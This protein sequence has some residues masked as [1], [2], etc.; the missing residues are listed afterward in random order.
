MADNTTQSLVLK[1][2]GW[3]YEAGLTGLPRLKLAS[4]KELADEYTK[5]SGT[6]QTIQERA[7]AL[8][9]A[10]ITWAAAAGVLTGFGGLATLPVGVAS[11]LASTYFVQLRMIEAIAIMGKYDVQSPQVRMLS[12][13][14]MC[15]SSAAEIATE[16]GV[17]LGE[18][19]TQKALANIS[20]RVAVDVEEKVASR[21]VVRVGEDGLLHAGR[22]IP[23]LGGLILGGL[24]AYMTNEIGDVARDLFLPP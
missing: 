17:N 2:L 15:G 11:D 4:S 10:Q 3:A 14:S 12:F 7:N 22:L 8:I 20:A 19:L 23:G 13:V 9:R 21:I 18:K 16:L 24:N 1:A 6:M 5:Q